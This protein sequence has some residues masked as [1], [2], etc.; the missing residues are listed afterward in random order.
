MGR[1]S[2]A[3]NR[4]ALYAARRAV[5]R[6]VAWAVALAIALA[7]A[8]AAQMM[9]PPAADGTR[10]PNA[11]NRQREILQEMARL[12]E[13]HR[14]EAE[15]RALVEKFLA[16]VK[17]RQWHYRDFDQVVLHGKAP[18]SPLLLELIAQSYYAADIAYYLGQHP[19]QAMSIARM[20]K[21]DATQAVKT[22]E[23]ELIARGV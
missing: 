17:P 1:V 23:S 12:Q 13:Q 11:D 14:D 8:A 6:A 9:G 16:A 22:I 21:A 10:D 2:S 20:P 18:V 5:A 7:G 3:I 19:D 4:D 15:H